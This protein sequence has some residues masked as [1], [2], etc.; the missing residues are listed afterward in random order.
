MT[1]S[2]AKGASAERE[3][4]AR[5]RPVWPNVGR[6]LEQV[7]RSSGRDLDGTEPWAIQIKRRARV[8][9]AVIRAGL[10]EA[11]GELDGKRWRFA[12]V[13]HRSDREP[14]RATVRLTDL[15]RENVPAVPVTM[16][17][18]DFLR[19]VTGE[20]LPSPARLDL[21]R[22]RDLPTSQDLTDAPEDE[23]PSAA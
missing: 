16:D 15:T 18:P 8:T 19:C 14:W 12:A 9:P 13:V 7:R 1:D 11:Q 3:V 2:R 22:Q 4:A 23:T 20:V 17:L 10:A 21:Q 5:L 6:N